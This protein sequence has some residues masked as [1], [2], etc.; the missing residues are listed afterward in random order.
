MRAARSIRRSARPMSSAHRSTRDVGGRGPY[1]CPSGMSPD[2]PAQHSLGSLPALVTRH[3][4]AALL[5]AAYA[6]PRTRATFPR[7]H[8]APYV[9]ANTGARPWAARTASRRSRRTRGSCTAGGRDAQGDSPRHGRAARDRDS[10]RPHSNGSIWT[11]PDWCRALRAPGRP[12][13]RRPGQSPWQPRMNR[14]TVCTETV[15]GVN[16]PLPKRLSIL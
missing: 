13:D 2:A 7:L 14:R 9:P 12:A 5:E 3:H 15:S 1:P 16:Y 11:R 10:G 8:D 6:L 4:P